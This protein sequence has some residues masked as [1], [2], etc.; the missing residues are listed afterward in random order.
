VGGVLPGM[1]GLLMRPVVC[2]VAHRCAVTLLPSAAIC[3]CLKV[4]VS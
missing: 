1:L 4:W 2:Q 3:W